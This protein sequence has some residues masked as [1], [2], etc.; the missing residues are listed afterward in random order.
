MATLE[1]IQTKIAKLQKQAESLVTK[2]SSA[3]L[4]KVRGLMERHG[5]TVADLEAHLGSKKRGRK[6]AVSAVMK[7]S[8]STAKYRD[9][10]SGATWSGRGRAPAWIATARD[11]TKFLVA[12]NAKSVAPATKKVA[13]AGNYVRGAQAPK[14]VDPKTGATW[15]GRGRAP[16]WLAGAKDRS[17]FLIGG[18]V[19]MVSQPKA[20]AAKA[21]KAATVTRKPGVKKVAAKKSAP[22]TKKNPSPKAS[23]RQKPAKKVRV[24]KVADKGGNGQPAQ[25]TTPVQTVEVASVAA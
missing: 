11:R 19:E 15:S 17:R 18:A 9:P 8:A 14:Y 4:E 13:K 7:E 3:V 16:A 21:A 5:I 23:T 24:I 2:Q 1:S 22:L 12:D 20:K 25:V 6:A 10:K